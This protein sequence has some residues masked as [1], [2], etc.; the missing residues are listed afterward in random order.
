MPD[1]AQSQRRVVVP[2]E[3]RKR[4]T[5]DAASRRLRGIACAFCDGDGDVVNP[6]NADPERA[7]E[8]WQRPVVCPRCG[9]TGKDPTGGSR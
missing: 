3:S 8:D 6:G 9:G 2:L 7:V 4:R 1:T 5:L